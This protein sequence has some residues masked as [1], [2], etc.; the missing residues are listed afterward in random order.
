MEDAKNKEQFDK[1][2]AVVSDLQARWTNPEIHSELREDLLFE[3][4]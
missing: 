3:L 1:L 2:V 4:E